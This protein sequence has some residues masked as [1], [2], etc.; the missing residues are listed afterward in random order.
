MKIII[1]SRCSG[2]TVRL[3]HISS[4]KNI[5]ILVPH[6]R[7][8]TYIKELADQF[9]LD[10]PEPIILSD[11]QIKKPEQSSILIDQADDVLSK[12]IYEKYGAFVEGITL[13]FVNGD[14]FRIMRY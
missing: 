6:K 9:C 14:E 4:T 11:L 2:K 5:P 1:G 8:A 10:I 12:L 7:N 13:P 3:V